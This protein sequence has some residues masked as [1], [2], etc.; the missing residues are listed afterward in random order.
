MFIKM[1]KFDIIN[2]IIKRAWLFVIMF[3]FF[4]LAFFILFM[5]QVNMGVDNP[6][7]LEE[8]IT[9]GD[10]LLYAT[11]GAK[12]FV[13]EDGTVFSY[14]ILWMLVILI[15]TFINLRYPADN[16]CGFGRHIL[17]LSGSRRAWWISKCVWQAL[18]V[19]IYYFIMLLA[20]A[21]FALIV[22]ADFSLNISEFLPSLFMLNLRELTPT[23]WSIVVPLLLHICT[24]YVLCLL[25]MLIS[26][27]IRP[28]M[29][30]FI[31]SAI[32]IFSVFFSSP[33]LI[34]NLAM[35]V[36]TE[37]ITMDE[38]INL[39]LGFIICF[40]LCIVIFII[41]LNKLKRMDILTKE[42]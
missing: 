1:L 13:L 35:L 3:L 14:P 31:I 8:K 23:P 34:G 16:L 32:L 21:S 42:D 18:S 10:M 39:C 37:N 33:L 30:F 4:L 40:S 29:S 38:P 9:I 20:A 12:R 24:V 19:C 22:G 11:G 5:Q 17:I 25:Q 15:I 7:I 2:G 6:N 28:L 41:G 26:F 36:R 27:Y